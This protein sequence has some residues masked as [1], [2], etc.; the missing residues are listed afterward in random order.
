MKI[1]HL[2]DGKTIPGRR[3]FE[4]INPADQ[5]VLAQVERLIGLDERYR[6]F[7]SQLGAL[8]RRYQSKAVLS[9]VEEHRNRSSIQ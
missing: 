3:Y 2:I 5:Q 7:A 9:F 1:D 6:P 4:T 8:A